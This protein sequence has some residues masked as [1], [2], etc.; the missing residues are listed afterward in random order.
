MNFKSPYSPPLVEVMFIRNSGV[1]C[2]STGGNEGI[3][4][5][6]WEAMG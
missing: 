6:D 4:F 5:E 1:I 3:Y 2:T